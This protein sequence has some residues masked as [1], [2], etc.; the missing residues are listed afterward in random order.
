[1][2][3]I[4]IA[5]SAAFLIGVAL[6]TLGAL[7]SYKD[8]HDAHEGLCMVFLLAGLTFFT[9]SSVVAINVWS[10]WRTAIVEARTINMAYSTHYTAEDLFWGGD[11]I[12]KLIVGNKFNVDL[13]PK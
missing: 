11:A 12:K 1:M 9:I 13:T 2:S 7:I 10:S 5:I 4:I 8:R 6:L 3:I